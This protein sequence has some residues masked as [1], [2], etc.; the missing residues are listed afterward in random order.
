MQTIPANE[1][2]AGLTLAEPADIH[3]VVTDSRKV[4]PGCVFVCSPVSAST[5]IPSPP[6]LT[7]TAPLISSPTIPWTACPRTALSSCRTAPAP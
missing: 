3:A 4:E 1:L 7:G 6:V 5:A 2:L